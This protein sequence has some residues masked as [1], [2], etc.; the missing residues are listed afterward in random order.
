MTISSETRKAGPYT[1]NG[2][3]TSFP[4]TFKVFAAADILVISANLLE[5]ESTL[6]LGTD[7]T[8][9]L[10]PN[11]DISP[12][13]SVELLSAL[14][15]DY[16]LVLTSAVDV[17]QPV[18]LTNQ[19]GFYPTVINNALDRLTIICQQLKESVGRALTLPISSTSTTDEYLD[20]LISSI[21]TDAAIVAV[22]AVTDAV[23]ANLAL[24]QAAADAASD[25]AD[26]ASQSVIDA[27]LNANFKGAWS[28]LTGALN[29]P[30]LVSHLGSR[31]NLLNNLADV[32]AS[33][34]GVSADWELY[35]LPPATGVAF[36]NAGTS[37]AATTVQAALVEVSA[38]ADTALVDFENPVLN[39]DMRVAQTGTSFSCAAGVTKVLDGYACGIAGAAVLTVSQQSAP[40]PVNPNAKWMIATVTTPDASIASTDYAWL[41]AAVEGYD[42]AAY[43]GQTFTVGFWVKSSVTGVHSVALRSGGIDRVYLATVNILV[44]NTPQF[45]SIT[46]PG[47]LPAAGTW[48]FTNGVG[49]EVGFVL[50]AGSFFHAATG[51]WLATSSIASSA[52]VNALATI[53]NVFGITDVQINPGSVAKKFKRLNYSDSLARCQRYYEEL[54]LQVGEDTTSSTKGN[55]HSWKVEK[56]IAPALTVAAGIGSFS[57]ATVTFAV[58]GVG[59]S[60]TGI[61]Q[62]SGTN[63]GTVGAFGNK[64]V[65]GDARL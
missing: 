4:F 43:V 1:G 48:N 35:Q 52:Q 29:K 21:S 10:N 26:A 13:G 27:W 65:I 36:S 7:Y 59:T 55:G 30:A 23:A 18:D 15:T 5:V 8:V 41:L 58:P 46:V 51:S 64:I 42:I 38:D 62:S 28:S 53:G 11:Q 40:T 56:R 47:G 20:N 22:D 39:G 17:L 57:T 37:V 6:L 50:A 16:K 44:A 34:P 19:G 63:I 45:A 61:Y 33:T 3:A 24:S 60:K 25:S 32:T 31:W 12:G 54:S 14:A 9:S 2:I 49:L